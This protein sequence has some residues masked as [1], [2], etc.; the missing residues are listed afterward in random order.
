MGIDSTGKGT[1]VWELI[2]EY[3][4]DNPGA[5]LINADGNGNWFDLKACTAL[6][7]GSLIGASDDYV[8]FSMTVASAT[9]NT[10][11]FVEMKL[12][13]ENP[14]IEAKFTFR[15]GDVPTLVWNTYTE[16]GADIEWQSANCTVQMAKCPS[17]ANMHIGIAQGIVT[18]IEVGNV[19]G[20][21]YPG[22]SFYCELWG[23]RES[24]I[25][26]SI[27]ILTPPSKTVYVLGETFNTAGMIV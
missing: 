3:V 26:K 25:L 10:T 16:L 1:E 27:S 13:S 4:T 20:N 11:Y 8:R 21:A 22:S 19:Q 9:S 12:P 6:F 18:G 15:P 23:V 14:I 7:F 2:T 24:I 5:F 17:A